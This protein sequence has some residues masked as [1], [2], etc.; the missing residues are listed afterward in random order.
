MTAEA[1]AE[2]GIEIVVVEREANSPAG[3]IVGHEREI[4]GDWR[5]VAVRQELAK[6]VGLVTLENE[7]VDPSALRW[8]EQNGIG[9]FPGPE[10][11]ETVQDK[12]R[13]KETIA[14]AGIP[15]PTFR[16]VESAE[17]LR[18]IGSTLGWPLVLKSRR[19]GYD[20][21]G[22]V[23][24]S[25]PDEAEEALASLA[26]PSGQ[27]PGMA[28][29]ESLFAEAFVPFSGELAVMVARG[30]DGTLA[31]YPTVETIQH[32]HICHEVIVPAR[33]PGSVA[34]RARD[35]AV[36]AV[37]AVGA[38]G[39]VGV[40]L[41]YLADGTV[42]YNELAPR[43][44]NS[45]HYTIEGC[46]TSQFSNHLRAVLGL[47]LGPTELVAPGVAMVNLLGTRS[48]VAQPTGVAA[49]T[50]V[51]DAFVHLYGK[52]DVRPLRKM[53]HVTALDASPEAA[54]ARARHAAGLIEW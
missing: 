36:A 3:Q 9:V 30:R 37:E 15:V 45:G 33:V 40:E 54:L 47:P 49:A 44:H 27:R 21:H 29:P 18:E 24:V 53:G 51:P 48:A 12:L 7:F 34:A 2:L 31:V 17:A 4:V 8:F 10:T 46:R 50:A 22:N 28:S 26:R 14:R 16:P 6:R 19:L 38:V 20:G 5:D 52:K 1:A 43:P 39:I 25:A 42:L 32:H 23:T 13:Q 11:L 35:L 41:F